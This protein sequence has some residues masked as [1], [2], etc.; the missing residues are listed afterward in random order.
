VRWRCFVE[1]LC[2]RGVTGIDDDDDGRKRNA[3]KLQYRHYLADQS[4]DGKILT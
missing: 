1:V 4:K 3:Q 2:S